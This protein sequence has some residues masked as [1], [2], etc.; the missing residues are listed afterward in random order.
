MLSIMFVFQA[1]A[2]R[3]HVCNEF[4]HRLHACL[5]C[6][7]FGCYDHNHIH[8]HAKD[9]DHKWGNKNLISKLNFNYV[10][11]FMKLYLEH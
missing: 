7:F 4:G 8:D 9:Q 1:T 5:C 10:Q 3:C 2:C 6:V 11:G